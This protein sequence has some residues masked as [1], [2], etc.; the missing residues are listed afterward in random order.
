MLQFLRSLSVWWLYIQSVIN[1]EF[2]NKSMLV[3]CWLFYKII[4]KMHDTCIKMKLVF[5]VIHCHFWSG[6]KSRNTVHLSVYL[7]I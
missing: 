6:A 4:K 7:W 3:I 2:V 1:M 5:D